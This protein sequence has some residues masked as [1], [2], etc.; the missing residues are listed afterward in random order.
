[1]KKIYIMIFILFTLL[2]SVACT[3]K[4]DMDNVVNEANFTRVVDSVEE[5]SIL[6]RVNEDQDEIKS[7]DLISV[8]LDMQLKNKEIDF[9]VGDKVQVYYDGVILE[10]YPAQI[11]GVYVILL[12]IDNN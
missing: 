5:K 10:S 7:S 11:N 3:K 9:K 6:V 2:V 8:S 1:M 4:I 12:E